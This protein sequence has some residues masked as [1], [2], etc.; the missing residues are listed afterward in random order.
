[1]LKNLS[2][3]IIILLISILYASNYTIDINTCNIKSG[4]LDGD[5]DNDIAVGH[6]SIGHLT[7]L[8]NNGSGTFTIQELEIFT[9]NLLI[10]NSLD[11]NNIADIVTGF[12]NLN[13][14]FY[15]V[16]FYNF[17]RI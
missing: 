2:S 12:R 10:V 4:D 3:V 6:S 8:I 1:M 17:L 15:R 9:A 5:G 16:F 7:F 14:E 13:N 11:D